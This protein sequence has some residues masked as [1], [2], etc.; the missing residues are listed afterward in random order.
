LY[1]K[2]EEYE[3]DLVPGIG[4]QVIGHWKDDIH[5]IKTRILFNYTTYEVVEAEA[6]GLSIPFDVCYKGMDSIKELVGVKA[7]GGYIRAVRKILMGKDGCMHVGE[8]AQNSL[9]AALNCVVRKTP[10][11]ADPEDFENRWKTWQTIYKDR[12]IYFS[13][14]GVLDQ[15]RDDLQNLLTEDNSE[16]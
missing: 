9:T 15:F 5:D 3:V 14:E 1:K 7:G 8:L 4:Y 13:Q 2:M 16:E 10:E 6:E 12:C 11:W